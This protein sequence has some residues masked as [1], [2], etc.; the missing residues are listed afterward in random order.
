MAASHQRMSNRLTHRRAESDRTN[1]IRTNM[2]AI[3]L[4][5]GMEAVQI[6]AAGREFN[7]LWQ[8]DWQATTP[9]EG[10]AAGISER[11]PT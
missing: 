9:K 2:W 4:V 11:L 8:P 5:G 6:D 7:Q 3:A 1:E 10:L